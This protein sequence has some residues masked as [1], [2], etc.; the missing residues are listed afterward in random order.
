M[1]RE[2]QDAAEFLDW[3]NVDTDEERRRIEAG[4][5][6]QREP[7]PRAS[8]LIIPAS[9][10]TELR[11]VVGQGIEP[12]QALTMLAE[13]GHKYERT[14]KRIAGLKRRAGVVSTGRGRGSRWR[15]TT[16]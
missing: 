3:A 13:A 8:V 6:T 11:R 12:R 9:P 15:L 16:E 14:G 4:W 7:E 1:T 2:E 5:A 10:E